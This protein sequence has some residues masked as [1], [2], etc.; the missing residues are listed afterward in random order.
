M[1]LTYLKLMVD[2]M[3]VFINPLV[4]EESVQEIVPGIFNDR[5]AQ[6]PC[7][8]HIPVKSSNK[9]RVTMT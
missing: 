1:L 9:Y 5:T 4:M 3:N 8:N 2:F 6:A 7:Q